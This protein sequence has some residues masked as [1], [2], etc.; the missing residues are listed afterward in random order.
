MYWPSFC[1]SFSSTAGST[2]TSQKA[3]RIQ[4]PRRHRT[5]TMHGI[6]MVRVSSSCQTTQSSRKLS[7][8]LAH[9]PS[10]W[11]SLPTTSSLAVTSSRG[12]SST[13]SQPFSYLFVSV[14]AC[15]CYPSTSLLT[16]VTDSSVC[17]RISP[18][19]WNV[20]N[21]LRRLTRHTRPRWAMTRTVRHTRHLHPSPSRAKGDSRTW[22][23][24]CGHLSRSTWRI[25]L[26]IWPRKAYCIAPLHLTSRRKCAPNPLPFLVSNVSIPRLAH[27][28]LLAKT[29][30][31]GRRQLQMS[32][33]RSKVLWPI[34]SR[35]Q[36]SSMPLHPSI[37]ILH[38]KIRTQVLLYHPWDIPSWQTLCHWMNCKDEKS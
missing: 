20:G 27:S 5:R 11:C 3:A 13:E 22:L 12:S 28:T 25:L 1:A 7:L 18:G 26:V 21:G 23:L 19:K 36:E 29:G 16:S 24:I 6:S 4:S 10:F 30:P 35:G 15:Y 32:V 31:P 37:T 17:S 34:E 38:L 14:L 33:P 2:L 9:L 8:A